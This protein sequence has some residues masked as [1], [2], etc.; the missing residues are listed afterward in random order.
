MHLPLLQIVGKT[1]Q[2]LKEYV[3]NIDSKLLLKELIQIL[4]DQYKEVAEAHKTFLKYVK[5]ACTVHNIN[6]T[7]YDIDYYWS[8]VQNVVR[9]III[10]IV[11]NLF[12][13]ITF[14]S[15]NLF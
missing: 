7:C 11:Q 15:F 12:T 8:Q 3:E 4:F 13:E 14:F 2:H 9:L 1:T 6:V 5:K 10:S